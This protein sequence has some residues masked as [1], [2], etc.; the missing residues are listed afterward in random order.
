MAT[1]AEFEISN[2]P[3]QQNIRAQMPIVA[4]KVLSTSQLKILYSN[5]CVMRENNF[6]SYIS[7]GLFKIV[8]TTPRDII[9]TGVR[10]EIN[11]FLYLTDYDL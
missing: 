11:L 5:I 1:H 4:S 2:F 7:T 8:T 10:L 6:K 3:P 9:Y